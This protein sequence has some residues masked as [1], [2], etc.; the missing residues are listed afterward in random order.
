MTKQK[1]IN[2][3]VQTAYTNITSIV[4]LDLIIVGN[5]VSYMIPQSILKN[6][7]DYIDEIIDGVF[8]KLMNEIKSKVTRDDIEF[9][10]FKEFL[11]K[12]PSS[13]LI[14]DCFDIVNTNLKNKKQ[15]IKN[16]LIKA[17]LLIYAPSINDINYKLNTTNQKELYNY[18][19][20]M[21]EDMEEAI[22][23]MRQYCKEDIIVIGLENSNKKIFNY[24][25]EKL[26][27]ICYENKIYFINPLKLN[28]NGK[29]YVEK[30]IKKI[31][32]NK[33]LS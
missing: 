6:N 3:A 1:I 16:A 26:G 20:E 21:L 10:E 28:K 24:I 33:I 12:N 4:D 19:D 15:T 23:L 27:E 30:E 2:E 22:K 7:P 31:I 14:K 5:Y 29:K 11:S 17:D 8:W 32:E 13:K 25:N 18:A 9:I